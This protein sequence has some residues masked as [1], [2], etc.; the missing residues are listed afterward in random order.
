MAA[1]QSIW[2]NEGSYLRS[3]KL[4]AQMREQAKPMFVYRQFV[5]LK[6]GLGK[7]NGDQVEFTKRLRISTAGT[8]LTETATMPKNRIRFLKD[9]IIVTEWGFHELLLK[10]A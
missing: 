8:S 7:N 2:V 4:S 1:Q 9:S 5:D 3:P 10:V 6:D